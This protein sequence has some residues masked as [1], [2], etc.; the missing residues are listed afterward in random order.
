MIYELETGDQ[1]AYWSRVWW[2][3]FIGASVADLVSTYI[4]LGVGFKEDN[5]VVAALIDSYGF[6]SFI[7][8]KVFALVFAYSAL[9]Y[10]GQWK[11]KL[12][13]YLPAGAAVATGFVAATNVIATVAVVVFGV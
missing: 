2:V 4:S 6:G 12:H 5:P 10:A 7:I 9:Y 11:P 3:L 13:V 8:F 1:I